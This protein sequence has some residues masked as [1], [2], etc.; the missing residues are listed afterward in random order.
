MISSLTAAAQEVSDGRLGLRVSHDVVVS[1][2]DQ[3]RFRALYAASYLAARSEKVIVPGTNHGQHRD[4]GGRSRGS[5]CVLAKRTAVRGQNDV[6]REARFIPSSDG[7]PALAVAHQ[8]DAILIDPGQLTNLAQRVNDLC[9]PLLGRAPF[10]A[11][12]GSRIGIGL[13]DCETRVETMAASRFA[14]AACS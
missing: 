3:N 12:P 5:S 11:V 14:A 9:V 10:A 4:S 13:D 8:N 2:W 7:P 6:C 1:I